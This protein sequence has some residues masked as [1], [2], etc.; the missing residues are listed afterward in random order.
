[1]ANDSWLVQG[2]VKIYDTTHIY[3]PLEYHQ[4]KRIFDTEHYKYHLTVNKNA[5][6]QCDHKNIYSKLLNMICP[7]SDFVKH[8][9]RAFKLA[10]LNFNKNVVSHQKMNPDYYKIHID[11]LIQEYFRYNRFNEFVVSRYDKYYSKP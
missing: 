1:M 7:G 2:N 4:I 5:F 11:E 3:A 6:Y 8:V 10:V 9:Q